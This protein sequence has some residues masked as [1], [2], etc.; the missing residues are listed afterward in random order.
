MAEHELV[1]AFVHASDTLAELLYRNIDLCLGYFI[2]DGQFQAATSILLCFVVGGTW[3]A[4]EV[5]ELID[6]PIGVVAADSGT[7]NF[8]RRN[9]G[10]DVICPFLAGNRD[11]YRP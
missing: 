10:A 4:E 1:H 6:Q 8:V 3:G 7:A 2:G 5:E 11:A 9:Y